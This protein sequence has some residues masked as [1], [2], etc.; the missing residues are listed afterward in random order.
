MLLRDSLLAYLHFVSIIATASV[1]VAEFAL[2]R[3]GLDLQRLKV[4]ARIDL[5]YLFL[6][7]AALATGFSRAIWGVKGWSFYAHNPVFW[8]KISLFVII[9]LISIVP[10]LR[11]IRWSKQMASDSIQVVPMDEVNQISRYILVEI[12]V[13][14]L[15]PLMAT[16]MSRGYGY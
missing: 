4:L 5:G 10:T 14:A 8:I 11:F 16:L 3:A 13:L 12:L 1:V 6:A 9:G 7:V 15:I 2:C